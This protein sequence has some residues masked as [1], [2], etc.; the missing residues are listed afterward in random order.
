MKR[1]FKR[2]FRPLAVFV[3]TLWA[4]RLWKQGL[5][6]ANER[7]RK[8][9][10]Q[11]YLASKTFLPEELTT[12]T[13]RQFKVEKR[14]FGYHARLL[15]MTTLKRGC[16][17]YTLNQYGTDGIS[18]KDEELRRQFFVKERLQLARLID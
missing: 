6:M 13:K 17:Y 1:F 15:T 14:A 5:E 12:Y 11:V 18:K 16:Y 8:E 3:V 10:V 2:L 4:N 7:H 9:G